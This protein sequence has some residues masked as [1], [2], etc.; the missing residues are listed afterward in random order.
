MLQCDIDEILRRAEMAEDAPATVGDE[1]L[2]AFKV[3][4]FAAF[5]EDKDTQSEQEPDE[6]VRDWV[7]FCADKCV[8]LV[9]IVAPVSTLGVKK[10]RTGS[11]KMNFLE[12]S[13]NKRGL[14]LM[15]LIVI[16]TLKILM[17]G[18]IRDF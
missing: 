9:I 17:N 16:P 13:F 4:S 2:S 15:H 7:S 18:H 11:R 5:E 12:W 14:R 6:E 8:G 1:L 3:A 10:S